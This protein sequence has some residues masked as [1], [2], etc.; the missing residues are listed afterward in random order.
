[1]SARLPLALL[2]LSVAACGA[3]SP[4]PDD[5]SALGDPLD[6]ISPEEL[7]RRGELLAQGGDYIRAEQYIAAAIQRGF[8][9]DRA[10]PALLSACVEGSRLVSALQYAEPYLARHPSQ[11]PLRMLVASIHMGLENDDRA[12]DELLQ[13]VR[14]APTEAQPHYFL[15]VLYRDR[16]EDEAQ[17]AE[18]FRQYLALAP[19]GD[20]REEAQAG[21]EGRPRLPERVEMPPE[22]SSAPEATE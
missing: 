22:E 6:S 4:R 11:W 20:H 17:A 1:M 13:V 21:L 9:E 5:A 3:A 18:H 7:Y 14:D 8:P 19:D 15:G 2:A 12:R 16:L 10:M